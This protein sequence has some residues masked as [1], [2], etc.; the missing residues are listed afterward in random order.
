MKRDLENVHCVAD[1]TVTA[2]NRKPGQAVRTGVSEM[3]RTLG[4]P[5]DSAVTFRSPWTG[6]HSWDEEEVRRA[7][8][9]R[10]PERCRHATR[11]RR[12]VPEVRS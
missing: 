9:M 3:G 8:R 12:S 1:R 6:A 4:R 2:R 5:S 7:A 11:S 10:S